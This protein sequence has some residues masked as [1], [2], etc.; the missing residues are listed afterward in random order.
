MKAKTTGE[1]VA[2]VLAT[3]TV[4]LSLLAIVVNAGKAEAADAPKGRLS[5]QAAYR[6]A[7]AL[8]E[9]LWVV[10]QNGHAVLTS[11]QHSI[12]TAIN[13]GEYVATLDCGAGSAP[14]TRSRTFKVGLSGITHVVIA[15]D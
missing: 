13:P 9:V 5:L 14:R 6:D 10:S 11:R 7:P 15:C 4:A 8:R 12:S 3:A 2:D 1:W